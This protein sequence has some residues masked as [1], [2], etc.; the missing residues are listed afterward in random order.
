M[1]GGQGNGRGGGHGGGHGGRHGRGHGAAHGGSAGTAPTPHLPCGTDI[2]GKGVLDIAGAGR[3][4][5]APTACW[6]IGP[7]VRGNNPLI[8]AERGE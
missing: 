5:G 2:I 3:A 8:G 4:S 6:Q 1:L 7:S